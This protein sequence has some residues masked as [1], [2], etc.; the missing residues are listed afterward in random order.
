M[1]IFSKETDSMFRAMSFMASHIVH[2]HMLQLEKW[3][4]VHALEFGIR[5][6]ETLV[7]PAYIEVIIFHPMGLFQC[8]C[9]KKESISFDESED[10]H[11]HTESKCIICSECYTA[12]L[13]VHAAVDKFSMRYDEYVETYLDAGKNLACVEFVDRCDQQFQEHMATYQDV[14]KKI[15]EVNEL[16]YLDGK[17]MQDV[18]QELLSKRV[19]R[20][21][22]KLVNKHRQ[23]YL[24][25]VLYSQL[26]DINASI[27]LAKQH[28]QLL[29]V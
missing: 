8:G 29:C 28:A 4:M 24:F 1:F 12:G 21:W 17:N 3:R 26:H 9:C 2:G 14:A 16:T 10:V 5:I 15:A 23:G 27:V 18:R 13:T 7:S 20:K 6:E 19:L 22:K 11:V 25:Q